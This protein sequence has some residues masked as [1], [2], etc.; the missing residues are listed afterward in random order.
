[1]VRDVHR[2][3]RLSVRLMDSTKGGVMV[4]DGSELSFVNDVKVK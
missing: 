1:M 2:L 4:H 3:A